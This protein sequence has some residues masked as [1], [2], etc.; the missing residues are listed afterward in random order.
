MRFRIFHK[1]GALVVVILA[2]TTTTALVGFAGLGAAAPVFATANPC[3]ASNSLG[4]FLPADNVSA[5]FSDL[6]ATRTYSFVSLVN[7]NPVRGVPGLVRYCVYT[8]TQPSSVTATASGWNSA[9]WTQSKG[10]DNFVFS[11]PGGNQSNIPLDG[12]TTVI[13]SATFSALPTSQTILLH[14]ND[15]EVCAALYGDNPVTCFV[16]PATGPIC[17]QGLTNPAYNAM[18]IGVVDCQNPSLGFEATTASEFGDEV[19]L[20]SGTS[21]QLNELQVLFA[22]FACT[23]GHWNTGNCV[24]TPGATFTHSITANIYGAS[25]GGIPGSLLATVTQD[26]V[27]PYRPSADSVNC[28]GGKWFNTAAGA[29]QNQISTVLTFTFSAGITLP[30]QVIWTVAFN[31]THYGAAPIGEGVACFGSSGGCPYDSLNVGAKTY[32]GAP[33]SGTDVD[34]NG[35]FVNYQAGSFYCDGGA[36][37]TLRL[38]TST[39]VCWSANKPLGRIITG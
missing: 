24:T 16:K 36:G 15:P 20:Q 7:E 10:S 28:T 12:K 9:H 4:S 35:A 34:P 29:C 30:D 18:P 14:I 26:Q 39:T 38:D 33:Y 19:S 22:S 2:I 1:T 13:G 27:I 32:T 8:S 17:N 5:T 23:S 31:T 6:G 21:R 11:R 3:P 25:S 37:G